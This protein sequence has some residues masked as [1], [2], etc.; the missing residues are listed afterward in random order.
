MDGER[1]EEI[2]LEHKHKLEQ[3]WDRDDMMADTDDA[4]LLGDGASHT[5]RPLQPRQFLPTHIVSTCT[6]STS[7]E[8]ESPVCTAEAAR[9]APVTFT[10]IFTKVSHGV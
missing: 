10:L 3:E 7:V 1:D 9:R 2:G 8:N 6:R 5:N 4:P